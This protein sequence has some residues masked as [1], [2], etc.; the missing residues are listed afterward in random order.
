M[1]G[2]SLTGGFPVAAVIH[3]EIIAVAPGGREDSALEGELDGLVEPGTGE[4]MGF[5][6]AVKEKEAVDIIAFI[7]GTENR[8]ELAIENR[9]TRVTEVIKQVTGPAHGM[10]ERIMAVPDLF[11][12]E[13]RSLFLKL[14]FEP[15]GE[16][17][18]QD[19]DI[20]KNALIEADPAQ[21]G[22][23]D[24]AGVASPQLAVAA[25]IALVRIASL[26][27]VRLAELAGGIAEETVVVR[28]QHGNVDIVVPGDEAPV[29]GGA[30]EGAGLEY[31]TPSFLQT[32]SSS[33]SM[34]SSMAQ[35]SFR[36]RSM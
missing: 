7:R 31:C 24:G 10:A 5:L 23:T 32:R 13:E 11:S 33:K 1:G 19:K 30:Q 12:P 14:G 21:L 28:A 34:S 6:R 26:E 36:F 8:L 3:G 18:V 17:L 2:G 35:S 25:V 22:R 27:E 20:Q 4:A 16:Q 9:G 15:L 29:P